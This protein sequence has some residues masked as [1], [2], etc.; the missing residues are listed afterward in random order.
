[1][2]LPL[3]AH[4]LLPAAAALAC[5]GARSGPPVEYCDVATQVTLTRPTRQGPPR[6][7]WT[8]RC[9]LAMV[10]VEPAGQPGN[11]W[12][13]VERPLPPLDY[14]DDGGGT[15]V[16][17]PRALTPGESYRVVW[18]WGEPEKPQIGGSIGFVY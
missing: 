13:R 15:V 4:W 5:T 14:G 8:P 1:M 2:N 11:A 9:R 10:A 7:E 16:E 3:R 6:F 12:W 17:G 18:A